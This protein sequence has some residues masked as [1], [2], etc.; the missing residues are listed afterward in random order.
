MIAVKDEDAVAAAL[1]PDDDKAAPDAPGTWLG[2]ALGLGIGLGLG[3]SDAVDLV[4]EAA[5]RQ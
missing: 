3:V 1:K 5:A 2:L 4:E